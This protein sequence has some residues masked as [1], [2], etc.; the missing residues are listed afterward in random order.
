[1]IIF[2]IYPN[3]KSAIAALRTHTLRMQRSILHLLRCLPAT[4]DFGASSLDDI[5]M[6]ISSS[7]GLPV[8]VHYLHNVLIHAMRQGDLD[9]SRIIARKLVHVLDGAPISHKLQIE[10]IGTDSW[11]G[12]AICRATQVARKETGL[13]AI[14]EPLTEQEELS[15]RGHIENALN[16]LYLHQPEMHTEIISLVRSIKLF[17]G[18]ITQGLTDTTV[19]GEIYIR[20]PRPCLS[21]DLYYVEHIVHEASHTYLN[22]LMA[23]DPIV[24][25]D[26]A[27]TFA[28]P[29]RSDPRPMYGVFHAT[30][31]ASRM[32]LSFREIYDKTCDERYIKLL[33]EVTDEAIRGLET[34]EHHASLTPMGRQLTSSMIELTDRIIQL[35]QLRKFDFDRKQP[36]R[37]GAGEARFLRLKELVNAVN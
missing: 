9:T 31:V 33:A 11:E 2:D 17:S 21:P 13:D 25:N 19:F 28:S 30:F 20:T 15:H 24:L 10:S 27:A 37:C 8:E 36:H 4:F 5:E 3:S 26:K 35:S 29:L 1:M 32:A 6:K 34:I 12:Q 16:I 14:A 18:K 22:C 23:A 7:A